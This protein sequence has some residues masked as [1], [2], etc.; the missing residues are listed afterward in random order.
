MTTYAPFA[1]AEQ[2]YVYAMPHEGEALSAYCRRARHGTSR[3]RPP[4]ALLVKTHRLF[5]SIRKE[6]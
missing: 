6:D 5:E 3:R 4:L 2:G 1:C